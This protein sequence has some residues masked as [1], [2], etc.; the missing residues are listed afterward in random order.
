MPLKRVWTKN[1]E[2]KSHSSIKNS[3]ARGRNDEQEKLIN[4]QRLGLWINELGGVRKKVSTN[5]IF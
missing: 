1:V 5:V 2:I 4:R 3:K